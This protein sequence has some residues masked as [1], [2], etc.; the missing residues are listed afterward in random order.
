MGL[1]GHTSRVAEAATQ[2]AF[3][4]AVTV[5][6]PTDLG[7]SAGKHS[8]HESRGTVEVERRQETHL[9]A[10]Y[11]NLPKPV[12]N[13]RRVVE[14]TDTEI[15]SRAALA[16]RKWMIENDPH[17]PVY[18]F[19]GPESW[20][21]DPNGP[22][23]HRGKYHLFY[24]FDPQVPDGQGNW[25]RSKRCWG[26]AVSEDLIHWIDWPVAI[27][28]DTQYDRN[29]VF[30][31]N[32]VIADNGNPTALYTG[33]VSNHQESYGM[34]AWS[35]DGFL[36]WKKRMVMHN[37][38]RP[39][40]SSP[41][42]WDAQV[43]KECDLWYQLVGGAKEGKGAAQ[44]WSSSDLLDWT[45]LKAVYS[46][47]PGDYWELPYLVSFG[48]KHALFVGGRNPRNPYWI[49]E[50][51]KQTLTFTPDDLRTKSI[52]NGTYY[53]FNLNM[54]D[55]KGPEGIKRQLM[56][57]WVTGP[58]SPTKGVPYWQGAHAIP[59]VLTLHGEHIAQQPIPE[60][61][62]LR[63]KHRRCENLAVEPGN[64]GY[65]PEIQGD[66]LE[67]IASFDCNTT[68]AARFGVK[69]RVS[70]DNKQGVDVWYDPKTD[71]FG[72]DGAVTKKAS[73]F[74]S[75]TRD[76][77]AQEPVTLR[78]FLDRSI[79]EVYCGGAALTTR[80]FAAPTAVAVDLFADGGNARLLS[81][82]A[83]QMKSMWGRGAEGGEAMA[84]QTS[85]RSSLFSDG[86]Q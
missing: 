44:I 13:Y 21:N 59:R 47:P 60:I 23:Y 19:T 32:T 39:N 62:V 57:G 67:L 16:L 77:S 75:I 41:V 5:C 9:A 2:E 66:A 12:A 71:Q 79:L 18:H 3:D 86:G 53:S 7:N 37:D 63:G 50:Y 6:H 43:W 82:D 33:N 55:N 68:R 27:W 8:L 70:E 35:E 76:G 45:Y 34:I 42:H 85:I 69:L 26:H 83:W 73:A 20:I 4:D 30:S 52:D 78:I 61:A 36:T 72:V 56:H 38:Q 10:Q 80:T 17:R 48:N 65:L 74:G 15:Y 58:P 54:T 40:P 1:I 14:S 64:G 31:G 29:G 84:K 51:D 22:I 46:G 25:R 28:P 49:G 81:L 11:A 24:Q